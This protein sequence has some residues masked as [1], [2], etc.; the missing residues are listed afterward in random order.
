LDDIICYWY[1]LD[2]IR[3]TRVVDVDVCCDVGKDTAEDYESDGEGDVSS[4]EGVISDEKEVDLSLF[5]DAYK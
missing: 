1:I 4:D 2:A 3:Q 5:K